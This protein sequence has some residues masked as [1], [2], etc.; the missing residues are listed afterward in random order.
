MSRTNRGERKKLHK[1]AGMLVIAVS[2]GFYLWPGQAL[3]EYQEQEG[4]TEIPAR[5][6][7]IKKG[8]NQ[9]GREI[10][11]RGYEET[12]RDI[13]VYGGSPGGASKKVVLSG[14]SKSLV[15]IYGGYHDG[16]GALV[17]KNVINVGNAD[18]S[19]TGWKVYDDPRKLSGYT[20]LNI[21]DKTSS[22]LKINVIAGHA[23]SGD[24]SGNVINIRGG[25]L[26]NYVIAAEAKTDSKNVN[27]NLHDNTVNIFANANLVEAKIYGAAL[28][29]DA[30]RTR[31][32]TMGTNNTV[33]VYVKD[34]AVGELA[35]F[36]IYNFHLPANAV[37]G[38]TMVTVT[39]GV[40]TDIS[41]STVNGIVQKTGSLPIGST[42][43]L[44]A[45][46]SGVTDDAATAYSG[47]H[48]DTGLSYGDYNSKMYDLVVKKADGQHVTLQVVGQGKLHP[49][50]KSVVQTRVPTLVNR[51]ADFL[52]GDAASSAD[53]AGAQVYTPFF[54]A[55]HSNMRHTTGSHVD[56]RGYSMV[57]GMSKRMET[58][59]RRTL[60]APVVEYGTGRYE[61][62][63][64]DGTRGKGNS[65]YYGLGLVFRN[66]FSNG[67]FYEGSVRGGRVK[68]DYDTDDYVFNG[69]KIHE[70]FNS[71]TYYLGIHLGAGREVSWKPRHKIT[72]YGKFY[73]TNI[74]AEK[75]RLST[76]QE[77]HCSQVHSERLRLGIRDT[78]TADEKNKFYLGLAWEHEFDGAAHATYDGIPTAAPSLRGNSGMVEL[79]W[80]MKP[81]GDDRWSIDLSATGWF[82]RQRGLT[83]RLGINWMF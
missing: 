10:V 77:Y 83:G 1:L 17:Q 6:M 55:S 12:D 29:H 36:N 60:I 35:A 47:T 59:K 27:K 24:V 33:N 11:I 7:L 65:R 28:F 62:A 30:D 70:H 42:V 79:G 14:G 63:L 54:A 61:T 58:P 4:T 73:Y 25:T 16:D 40:A 45:N 52:S 81:Q 64:D 41:R 15:D 69:R 48:A 13:W 3:A 46:A 8:E 72:Y 21:H 26:N 74:G 80:V 56:M 78:Y 49:S 23:K 9:T 2:T 75:L 37:S 57:L 38:D 71:S 76:G 50:T 51:G 44:L 66:T 53:A 43:N 20:L 5:V 19:V 68:L 82:G 67:K 18:G 31:R 32:A 39:G 34:L 22:G